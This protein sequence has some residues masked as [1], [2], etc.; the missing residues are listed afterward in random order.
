MELGRIPFRYRV[1]AGL[2]FFAVG[3]AGLAGT[4]I[5]AG[6]AATTSIAAF[7][8]EMH[9][10]QTMLALYN[11]EHSRHQEGTVVDITSAALSLF[12]SSRLMRGAY[13][14]F[15]HTGED[16]A[17]ESASVTQPVA[18]EVVDPAQEPASD[19]EVAEAGNVVVVDFTHGKRAS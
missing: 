16:V 7:K 13:R 18:S 4:F 3:L 10:D 5:E 2:G 14:R 15:M 11:D 8:A 19:S 6:G 17:T 1:F 9:D 12:V